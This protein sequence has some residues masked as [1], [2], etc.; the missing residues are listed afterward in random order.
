MS[1]QYKYPL[2][3]YN[4]GPIL[5]CTET[6]F[7]ATQISKQTN[8]IEL[9]LS[10]WIK[11]R[12]DDDDHHKNTLTARQ[13]HTTTNI[14]SSDIITCIYLF[15]EHRKCL[16]LK[17]GETYHLK[18]PGVIHEYL[19]IKLSKNSRILATD[20]PSNDYSIKCI[21]DMIIAKRGCILCFANGLETGL[22]INCYGNLITRGSIQCK[23]ISGSGGKWKGNA[24][25]GGKIKL[26]CY[27]RIDNVGGYIGCKGGKWKRQKI[28][29]WECGFCRGV[30]YRMECKCTQKP[31]NWVSQRA[32]KGI[33]H[34]N[35]QTFH[36]DL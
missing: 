15:Y 26:Y 31:I 17:N 34:I 11:C 19:A 27:G 6:K 1:S 30:P 25:A 3:S 28:S 23:G 20:A 4:A 18:S 35:G 5:N 2:N 22:K 10:H 9:L 36:N 21:G 8:R 24:T 29:Y 16:Y 7:I 33:I 13:L 32:K 14:I 12:S